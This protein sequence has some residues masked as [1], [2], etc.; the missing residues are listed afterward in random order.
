MEK[1]RRGVSKPL[2]LSP[3]SQLPQVLHTPNGLCS[4]CLHQLLTG[5]DLVK[6]PTIVEV[7]LLHGAP[8]T[9]GFLH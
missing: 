2:A 1:V 8:V 5:I 7:G 3:A 4:T 6:H 9:K